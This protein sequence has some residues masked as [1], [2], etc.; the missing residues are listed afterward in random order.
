MLEAFMLHKLVLGPIRLVLAF[1]DFFLGE[2][3]RL[4]ALLIRNVL[5]LM[6][7]LHCSVDHDLTSLEFL[8]LV[9]FWLSCPHYAGRILGVRVSNMDNV[10]VSER[11]V[12]RSL[13]NCKLS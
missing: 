13:L 9:Y 8:S 2:W 12:V 3:L 11:L 7:L 6:G 4:L 5:T 1:F 10:T